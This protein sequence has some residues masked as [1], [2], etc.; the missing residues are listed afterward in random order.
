MLL[1]ILICFPSINPTLFGS[2]PAP[3]SYLLIMTPGHRIKYKMHGMLMAKGRSLDLL[4]CLASSKSGEPPKDRVSQCQTFDTSPLVANFRDLITQLYTV[5]NL[6]RM[7]HATSPEEM[8]VQ[9]TCQRSRFL[10][11]RRSTIASKSLLKLRFSR[12]VSGL[13]IKL[14]IA[15]HW[16]RDSILEELLLSRGNAL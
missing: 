12:Q 13:N 8:H 5:A 10:R 2:S 14:Y 16:H 6:K 1:L 15:C 7:H 9:N 4:T 11:F 3:R